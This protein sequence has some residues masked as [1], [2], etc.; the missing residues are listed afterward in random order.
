MMSKRSLSWSLYLNYLVHGIGL[1]IL[2]QNMQALSQQWHSPLATVSYVFSG[3]GIGRI[4]AYFLFGRLSDKFG[5]KVFVNVGMVS[6]LIFFLG[7][8]VVTNLQV[9]YGLAIL[10]GVANS[11]LDSGTYATFIE[12]GGRQGAANILVKAFVSVGEFLLPLLVAGIEATNAWYGLSFL[13]ASVILVGN[14]IC[15]NRQTF[16]PRNRVDTT[17]ATTAQRLPKRRRVLASVGLAGYGYTS[18][19][20]MILYTQWIS[21]FVTR[22]YG[23]GGVL[24]HLLLSLYSIGSITGVLVV[25]VLLRAGVAERKL[26]L[27]MTSGSFIAL[28]AICY[29][30]IPAVAI[31]AAFAF[32]FLAAGGAM[33]LGLN[34]FLRLYPRIKGTITGLFFTFSSVATFT[35][36]LF[37][38]W[39]STISVAAAMRSD[40]VVALA[41]V[42]CVSLTAWALRPSDPLTRDRRAINQ[43]DKKVVRLLNRRFATVTDISDVKR[44]QH[45]PVLDQSREERVLDQVAHRSTDTTHTP[46]LQTIY[47]TIM[48]Q[49]RAYQQAR[50]TDATTVSRQTR[51]VPTAPTK[52]DEHA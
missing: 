32:G 14:L 30:G 19:A 9:A 38:G 29:V 17:T 12:M 25:F 20:L 52:E 48:Q 11:A 50:R 45:L 24:A 42:L 49:S 8:A 35:V 16:P 26:L 40:L 22:T 41:G 21:L 23:F 43:I 7:M 44:T 33:Q 18:M 37:T 46:Y 13:L 1:I 6:Y 5:R 31:V 2:T 51:P 28:A 47:Q 36:P 34:L 39:L 15:L 3:V 27:A 4:L 10:A